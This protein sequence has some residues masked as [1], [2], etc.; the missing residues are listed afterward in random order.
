[1]VWDHGFWRGITDSETAPLIMIKYSSEKAPATDL[2]SAKSD[3]IL[4][5]FNFK[6]KKYFLLQAPVDW[7]TAKRLAEL[8]GGKLA[9]PENSAELAFMI[10]KL[11]A[12]KK[13]KIA[14]GGYRK[15]GKWYWINGTVGPKKLQ[16]ISRKNKTSLN[17]S[18]A[19]VYKGKLCYAQSFD[20]FLCE[21]K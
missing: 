8:A 4:D 1:M 10:R 19:A 9:A 7:H 13:L 15:L 5:K 21:V 6:G 18:F 20:A 11:K 12:H 14:V 3:L 16:P 17:N 2:S